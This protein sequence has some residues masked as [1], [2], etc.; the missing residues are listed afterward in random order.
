ML[1]TSPKYL[2]VARSITVERASPRKFTFLCLILSGRRHAPWR[3]ER[4]T[5]GP[6]LCGARPKVDH[7]GAA[8]FPDDA[9][10]MPAEARGPNWFDNPP[11]AVAPDV[12]VVPGFVST[13][14]EL[15]RWPSGRA[16]PAAVPPARGEP[17]ACALIAGR[18]NRAEMVQ[19][20]S[21]AAD[22]FRLTG[23]PAY[24]KKQ[25]D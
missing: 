4:K 7:C 20:R 11:A 9:R 24:L 5:A 15:E 21:P 12:G 18:R 10:S 2:H 22:Q 25:R 23:R 14:M 17:A 16:C 19:A 1:A 6:A 3:G 8:T 13:E